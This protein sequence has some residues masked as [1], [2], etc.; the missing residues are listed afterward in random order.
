MSI[1]GLR[2][3]TSDSSEVE[4]T[5]KGQKTNPAKETEAALLAVITTL[6]ILR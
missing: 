2:W 3:L 1:R 4:V 5:S 6:A